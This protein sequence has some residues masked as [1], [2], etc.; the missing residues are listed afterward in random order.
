MT[1]DLKDSKLQE[2]MRN[3]GILEENMDIQ[4]TIS[5]SLVQQAMHRKY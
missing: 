4:N 1:M 3:F 5:V 2:N